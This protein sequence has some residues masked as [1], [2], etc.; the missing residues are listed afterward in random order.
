MARKQTRRSVSLS[1]SVYDRLVAGAAARG[2]SASQL[3]E[4]ALRPVLGEP[5]AA[6][7]SGPTQHLPEEPVDEA[8]DLETVRHD[9]RPFVES[10]PPAGG[11][12]VE[13]SLGSIRMR[14]SFELGRARGAR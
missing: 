9:D 2:I 14:A 13:I 11:T 8:L 7:Q 6:E 5:P 3:V 4:L 12:E 10:A 1:R